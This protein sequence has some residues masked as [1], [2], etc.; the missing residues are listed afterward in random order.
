[1]ATPDAFVTARTLAPPSLNTTLW[2]A[3]AGLNAAVALNEDPASTTAG[4]LRRKLAVCSNV[5]EPLTLAGLV[6]AALL[7]V[8]LTEY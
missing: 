7:A 1:M 5:T 4:T 3:I 2:P 6:P 8:T